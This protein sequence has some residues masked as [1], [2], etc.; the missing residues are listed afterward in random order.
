ML[1][2]E[3]ITCGKV[4]K[5]PEMNE[6]NL[7]VM[8]G[9]GF[10]VIDGVTDRNGSSYDGMLSGRFASHVIKHA[11][12]TYFLSQIDQSKPGLHFANRGSEGLVTFLTDAIY[13]QYER[14]EITETARTDWQK[15]AACA[16]FAV[17]LGQ[18]RHEMVSVGDCGL[19]VNLKDTYQ[20]FKPLDEI[21][22]LLRLHA[23]KHFE[24]LRFPEAEC[25]RLALQVARLG[26]AGRLGEIEYASPD[27]LLSIESNV[28]AECLRRFPEAPEEEIRELLKGGFL[29]GQGGFQNV[30]GRHLGYGAIDGFEVPTQYIEHRSYSK[31]DVDVIELFTDGYFQYGSSFGVA[32]W[33]QAFERVE[34]QDPYKIGECLS[35]K[36]STAESFADDRT[37]LGVY[38]R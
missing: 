15:R 32:A 21:A 31:S 36:G 33:E 23:W 17:I 28:L 10:A 13:A 29:L 7:V 6:D 2:L 11:L 25:S 20:N 9:L 5:R 34:A 26:T 3:A 30:H 12:E 22:A 37:Y 16:F 19:R 1:R 35:T 24:S 4:R 8:P 27:E 38:L 18:D 14:F